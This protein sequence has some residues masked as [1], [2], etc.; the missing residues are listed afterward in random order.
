M[1]MQIYNICFKYK[2]LLFKRQQTMDNR[3]QTTDVPIRKRAKHPITAQP[4]NARS[5]Q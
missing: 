4:N 2:Q 1:D 5:A 3:Q